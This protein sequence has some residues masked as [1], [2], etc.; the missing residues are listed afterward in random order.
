MAENNLAALLVQNNFALIQILDA[1]SKDLEPSLWPRLVG[2]CV[3]DA[4]LG[5][6]PSDIDIATPLHPSR[7][8]QLLPKAKLIPI[9]IS[10]GTLKVILNNQEFEI[11]TLRRDIRCDGRHASVEFTQ[12]FKIDA[13]R[14]DFTIN[15]LSYCPFKD[16]IFD[17]FDG[18]KHLTER[19]VIFIGNPASRI[20]E[21][22][23][24]IMRF[25]RFSAKYAHKLDADGYTQ[26]ALH[27]KH[28]SQIS[29]ERVKIELDRILLQQNAEQMLEKMLSCNVLST[30]LPDLIF[31]IKMFGKVL[32]HCTELNILPTLALLYASF[33]HPNHTKKLLPAL[34]EKKFSKKSA[35]II[36][37][38]IEE[39]KEPCTTRLLPNK[40]LARAYK[41][42]NLEE[43][44]ILAASLHDMS[45]D[46]VKECINKIQS[47][48]VKSL[49]VTG[50]DLISLGYAGKK[51]GEKLGILEKI[52][53]QSAFTLSKSNLL[54]ALKDKQS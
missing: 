27:A 11:T 17:Y 23:L 4:L 36:V 45:I 30:I 1:L 20:K 7:I 34:K 49:P 16:K 9:G 37:T 8:I 33:L 14:R 13:E 29:S 39:I 26:C 41:N 22:Y 12:D 51:I 19:K 35:V 5:L 40:L 53:I 6:V 24:R 43:Y 44:A 32:S 42:Q 47:L 52:W 21:D 15:A 54:S 2:G 48:E 10:F 46:E 25:F 18:L 3:R 38:L 31:D 50:S 28:L